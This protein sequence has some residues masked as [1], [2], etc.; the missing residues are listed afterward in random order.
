MAAI[1]KGLASSLVETLPRM[2]Q[3]LAAAALN[4]TG[5]GGGD[6]ISAHG[7]DGA[8]GDHVIVNAIDEV[9]L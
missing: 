2:L 7:E 3:M 1:A 4:V 6:N 8:L 9:F 5:G